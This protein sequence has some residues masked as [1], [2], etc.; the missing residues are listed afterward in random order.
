MTA[1][2]KINILLVDDQPSKLLSLET[3]LADLDE[4][5]IKA[6]SADEALKCLLSHECAVILVD[7]CMPKM[8]GFE[9]AEL[10]RSHPRFGRT[11]IIFISA[12]YLTDEDRLRGYGLGAVDYIPVPIIPEVLRAKVAVFAELYRKTSELRRVNAELERRLVELDRSNERLR[13]ADR[14]ATIGTLVAGL[15]HDMGNLLLPVRLRLDTLAANE[16][17]ESAQRD[18][19]AI[20]ES[21]LYLQ[22]LARSL[23]LLTLDTEHRPPSDAT[24]NLRQWWDETG[25]L[26]CGAVSKSIELEVDIPADLPEVQMEKAA[27]T[28]AVFNLIQNANDA[29]KTSKAGRICVKARAAGDGSRLSLSVTDN[30]PGMDDNACRR[31]VEPFFTTKTRELGTGLGLALVHGLVTRANGTL[32]VESRP[33]AGSCFTLLLP[34]GH[35][36]ADLNNSPT[37][38]TTVA[39]VSLADDRLR[40]HVRSI[41]T[42]L[43]YEIRVGPEADADVL[44]TELDGN[45]ALD[46]VLRFTACESVRRSV[47]FGV[48]P[49]QWTACDRIVWLDPAVKPSQLRARLAEVLTRPGDRPEKPV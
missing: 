39:R 15:G 33:G 42:S 22:R 12:V 18:V 1:T 25:G 19:A 16:L 10:I 27:L 30:G 4:N 47:V 43:A 5:V 6:N 45:G 40:A 26:L 31:C 32:T 17:P 7:V 14:M 29:L 8:D 11:A 38:P 28:Q 9:L 37:A 23:R 48:A 35:R 34:V 41:L 2:E 21:T 49:P 44:I 24:T 13:F 3:I 20:R 36:A 46:E